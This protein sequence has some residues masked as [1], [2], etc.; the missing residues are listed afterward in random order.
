M[1]A[2][3][4]AQGSN[5]YQQRGSSTVRQP[6]SSAVAL[7]AATQP[8]PIKEAAGVI[9]D[10]LKSSVF[11]RRL[12]ENH[13]DR[14]VTVRTAK[15]QVI[16]EWWG[17]PVEADV[18]DVV[19]P[20]AAQHGVNVDYRRR[21]M[22]SDG[23]YHENEIEAWKANEGEAYVEREGAC[24]CCG[25]GGEDE[26]PDHV[27]EELKASGE[28]HT[29]VRPGEFVTCPY[30]DGYGQSYRI[31]DPSVKRCESCEGRGLFDLDNPGQ[32]AAFADVETRAIAD[33]WEY[34]AEKKESARLARRAHAQEMLRE[35]P[36]LLEG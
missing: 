14:S 25:S 26:V 1:A 28:F 3:R 16:V 12:P 34:A 31:D 10:E 9:R 4:G 21:L 29:D 30:C 22:W 11:A 33:A 27:I 35:F 13:R 23:R 6:R 7:V 8:L 15:G 20:F 24:D 17:R 19:D 2:K 32:A 18:T 36:D 5:Q